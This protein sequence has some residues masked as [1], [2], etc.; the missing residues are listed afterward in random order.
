MAEGRAMREELTRR[1]QIEVVTMMAGRGEVNRF[2]YRL[3]GAL[4]RAARRTSAGHWTLTQ[5]DWWVDTS[6]VARRRALTAAQRAA[7][8]R[9]RRT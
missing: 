1:L 8:L 6:T 2:L 5:P 4:E 7:W 3:D 9:H